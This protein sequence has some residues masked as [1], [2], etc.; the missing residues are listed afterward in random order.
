MAASMSGDPFDV[1]L[2]DMQ[3]PEMDGYAATGELRRRGY[4]VPIVALTANAMR[5]DRD[6]CLAAG[7]TDYLSKPVDRTL[8][9]R[10]IRRVTVADRTSNVAA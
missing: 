4:G 1:V 10:M 7:C 6:R 5:E 3:M 8:L 9:V 2:M